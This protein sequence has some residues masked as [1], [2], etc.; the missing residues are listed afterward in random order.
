MLATRCGGRSTPPQAWPGQACAY[1]VGELAIWRARKKAE[2]QMGDAF[3][4]KRFHSIL[5]DSGPMPLDALGDAVDRYIDEC[6]PR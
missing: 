4:L 1:K 3:D 5:L 6:G 2:A